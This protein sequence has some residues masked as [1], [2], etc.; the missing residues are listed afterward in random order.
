MGGAT[1]MSIKEIDR[2]EIV[3]K[4]ISSDLLQ[5]VGASHLCLSERQMRRLIRSYRIHGE[6]GL[7]SKHIGKIPGNK[8]LSDTKEKALMLI[9]E[10]YYDF[11]PTLAHEY[12]TEQHDF[13]F[14]V[15]TVRKIM[16]ADGIWKPKQKKPKVHQSR[17]RR[18]CYGELIQIDGSP[19]DWFEERADRCSLLVFID[20]ATGRLMKCH[21]APSES[22]ESYMHALSDYLDLHGSPLALYS[23]KHG[24]FKVNHAGKEH[25]LTQFGR[26]IEE[27]GIAAIFAKTPQA[28]GRVERAN[29]TLQDR[30]VKALRLKNISNIEEANKY[31]PTFI[32]DYNSRFAVEP[33]SNENIHRTLQYTQD[34][35][36]VILSLQ[37][38]RKLTKNLTISYNS[39]EYQLVGCGKGYRLQH[40][41]IKVCKH[42]DGTVELFYD[43]KRLDYKCFDKGKAPKTS[44]R[45]GLDEIINN[46]KK[47]NNIKYKP[48]KDHP[49]RQYQNNDRIQDKACSENRTS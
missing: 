24:V 43:N 15:E 19:H 37:S 35:K 28:K 12:L 22:T 41:T 11:G 36:R 29:Q 14:S 27:F 48:A 40:K 32:E 26:A 38:T 34:E 44:C 49:W 31:L 21:F 9:Y 42:F 39:T 7:E 25:E 45:K 5:S 8:I 13:R 4:C 6:Q 18:A 2:L 17:E 16:I 33:R 30:L 47:E 1:T 3:K 10:K 20:D 23:D 46:I